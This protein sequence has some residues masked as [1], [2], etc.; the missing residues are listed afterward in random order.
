MS[1]RGSVCLE[2]LLMVDSKRN[3]FTPVLEHFKIRVE[4]DASKVFLSPRDRTLDLCENVK[5]KSRETQDHC[6]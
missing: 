4:S 3:N 1:I 2:S 5:K 6:S